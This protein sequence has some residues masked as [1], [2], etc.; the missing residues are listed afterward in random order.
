MA[1]GRGSSAPP[2]PQRTFEG[3]ADETNKDEW[4]LDPGDNIKGTNIEVT[5]E[6]C[7]FFSMLVIVLEIEVDTAKELFR[8]GIQNEDALARLK[9]D[10]LKTLLKDFNKNKSDHF[11]NFFHQNFENSC[12][13][14]R[15]LRIVAYHYSLVFNN[16]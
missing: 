3:V 11:R 16:S 15:V 13:I 5:A 9:K 6:Q 4:R 2:I 14:I 7:D 10:D 12:C 8:H 1:R